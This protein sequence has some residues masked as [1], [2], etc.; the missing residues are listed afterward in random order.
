MSCWC[1][2]GPNQVIAGSRSGLVRWV[3]YIPSDFQMFE[4]HPTPTAP[5]S[6]TTPPTILKNVEHN[7]HLNYIFS[8]AYDSIMIFQNCFFVLCG[9]WNH[10]FT[11]V[12]YLHTRPLL[13]QFP[14]SSLLWSLSAA[15]CV[16]ASIFS[17]VWQITI[18]FSPIS[19][20]SSF[21]KQLFSFSTLSHSSAGEFVFGLRPA[22]L[23]PR[24]THARFMSPLCNSHDPPYNAPHVWS[25]EAGTLSPRLHFITFITIDFP[26]S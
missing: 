7:S 6:S 20:W 13:L 12:K 5:T 19:T 4:E 16:S 1:R 15:A 25:G 24:Q 18:R 2:F 14:A 9:K 22:L 17:G 23:S 21:T 10:I 8:S 26:K 3:R 11:N